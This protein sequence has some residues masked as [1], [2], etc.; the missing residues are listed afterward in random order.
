MAKAEYG[1]AAYLQYIR[2]LL[3]SSPIS[4]TVRSL[5]IDCLRIFCG[6]D[7]I[8]GAPKDQ[9][10]RS[11][12][13][14]QSSRRM[15]KVNCLID[16]VLLVNGN[17]SANDAMNVLR[18][19]D[20]SEIVTCVSFCESVSFGVIL[21]RRRHLHVQEELTG[22]GLIGHENVVFLRLLRP[23]RD[24]HPLLVVLMYVVHVVLVFSS[25]TR[26]DQIKSSL[27]DLVSVRNYAVPPLPPRQTQTDSFFDHVADCENGEAFH[28]RPRVR[29]E[30]LRIYQ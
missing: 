21:G 29:Q 17:A 19:L 13:A 1:R 12:F 24:D 30:D 7:L 20:A 25:G 3:V 27:E 11:H 2:L 26:W 9:A 16:D 4:L 14:V 18:V 22:S 15:A 23:R 10:F 28:R 5:L 8:A 6:G